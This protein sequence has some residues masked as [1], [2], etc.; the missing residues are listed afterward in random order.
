MW[1]LLD[2]VRAGF[3]NLSAVVLPPAGSGSAHHYNAQPRSPALLRRGR[4]L[5]GMYSVLQE[6]LSHAATYVSILDFSHA[7]EY[8]ARARDAADSLMV[9]VR[10]L[11]GSMKPSVG[12]TSR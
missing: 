6:E 12:C 5:E 11:A 4:L 9:E 8:V 2:D 3:A 1:T 7:M 10:A